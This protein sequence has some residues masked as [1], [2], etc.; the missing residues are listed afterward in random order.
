MRKI[1][2]KDIH[3]IGGYPRVENIN[4]PCGRQESMPESEDGAQ[5]I[6]EEKETVKASAR[7]SHDLRSGNV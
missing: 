4:C 3:W 1:E 6:S 5:A 2:A 7:F